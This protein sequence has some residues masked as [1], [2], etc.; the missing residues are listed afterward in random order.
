MD[1]DEPDEQAFAEALDDEMLG[2]EEIVSDG[3]RAH[4][5]DLVDSVGDRA[6]REV[7]EFFTRRPRF[8]HTAQQIVGTE[9][10]DAR[11][12]RIYGGTTEIMKEIIGRALG[13]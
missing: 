1:V 13:V 9:F 3:L 12:T 2:D 6:S 4:D 11:V 7:P 5:L 8:D 10:V